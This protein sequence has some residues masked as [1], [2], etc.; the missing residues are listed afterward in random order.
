M[1]EF[2]L[3]VY[4]L[5]SQHFLKKQSRG[6]RPHSKALYALFLMATL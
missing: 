3:I 4:G 2:L 5:N 6:L 1:L